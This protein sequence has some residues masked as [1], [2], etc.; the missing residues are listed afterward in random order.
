[1]STPLSEDTIGRFFQDA[2]GHVWQHVSYCA[3]PTATVE[4]VTR[5]DGMAVAPKTR[6]GGAIGSPILDELGLLMLV[7]EQATNS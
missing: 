7:P 2:S 5:G 3:Y 4:L 1:M 6:R